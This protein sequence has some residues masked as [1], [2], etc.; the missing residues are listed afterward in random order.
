MQLTNQL[1]PGK[2]AEQT[3]MCMIYALWIKIQVVLL[4]SL[5]KCVAVL[6]EMWNGTVEWNDVTV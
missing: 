3:D 5:A 2:H 6:T 1:V 4:H